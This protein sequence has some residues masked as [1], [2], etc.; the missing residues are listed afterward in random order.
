MK[1]SELDQLVSSVAQS[2]TQ[3]KGL[4]RRRFLQGGAI[5]ASASAVLQLQVLRQLQ[6]LQQLP[7][8]PSLQTP[9]VF[10]PMSHHGLK[11]SG[12]AL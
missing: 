1:P 9:W 7:V 2:S 12:G 5:L 4:D 6:V 10:R 11:A 3:L 8:H